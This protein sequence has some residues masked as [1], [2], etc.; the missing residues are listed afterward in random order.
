MSGKG[1]YENTVKP[2]LDALTSTLRVDKIQQKLVAE[3]LINA[4][5]DQKLRLQSTTPMEHATYFLNDLLR[6]WPADSYEKFCGVIV[7]S[8]RTY[9]E[10][11]TVAQLLKLDL[12]LPRPEST[13]GE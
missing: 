7:E 10:H 9:P 12:L 2:N 5:D 8:V 3:G 1:F 6:D 13:P 4:R 11:R